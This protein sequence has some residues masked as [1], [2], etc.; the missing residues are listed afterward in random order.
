M[1]L[2][3]VVASAVLGA[4][5]Q[6]LSAKSQTKANNAANAA[7]QAAAQQ[8]L[9]AQQANFNRIDEMHQPFVQGG[10]AGF[11]QLLSRL[12]V[13]ST[14]G[15]PSDARAAYAPRAPGQAQPTYGKTPMGGGMARP[16]PAEGGFDP[17]A[18]YV[19]GQPSQPSQSAQG[20]DWAAYGAQNPDVAAEW[21]KLVQSGAAQQ[22]GGDPNAYFQWH[23]QNHGQA[24]GRPAPVAPQQDPQ[25]PQQ[26]QGDAGMVPVG[27]DYQNAPPPTYARPS[28]PSA[29]DLNGYFRNF[30]ADPGYA[31]RRDEGLNGVNAAW[32]GRGKLRS[33]DAAK[34]LA[35]FN[36]GLASQEYGNFFSRGLQRANLDQ[37]AFQFGAN[38][39]DGNFADDRSY[40]TNL[41]QNQRDY[42]TNRYDTQTSN[43][44]DIA[45]IG[46]RGAGQVGQAG[47]NLANSQ[48]DIY[49]NQADAIGQTAQANARAKGNIYSGIATAGQNILNPFGSAGRSP[50]GSFGVNSNTAIGTGRRVPIGVY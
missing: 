14:A 16:T 32:A 3:A 11:D 28:G 12:G 30:E 39:S 41:W 27:P 44:F 26:P 42:A 33:G 2:A 49:G 48:S 18:A 24:E 6:I 31:F 46:L 37:N 35:T 43:L 20:Q 22:F 45:G 50:V 36:S 29:P 38:R 7:Q 25:A 17:A 40:G 10:V 9:A 34:A 13:T 15:Q 5:A 4:G 1:P 23:Y 47:T 21:G 19:P 8:Q